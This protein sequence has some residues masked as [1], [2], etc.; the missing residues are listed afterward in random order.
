MY[1][2]G[3]VNTPDGVQICGVGEGQACLDA[4]VQTLVASQSLTRVEYNINGVLTIFM[5][6]ANGKVTD[7]AGNVICATGGQACL[8]SYV[9]SQVYSIAS[10]T[11]DGVVYEFHLYPDGSVESADGEVICTSGGETCLQAHIQSIVTSQTTIQAAETTSSATT[12]STVITY[13]IDGV[14]QRFT[15]HGDGSVVD[16]NGAVICAT[17]GQAC[18]EAWVQSQV[19]SYQIVTVDVYGEQLQ[20]YLYEDGSVEDVAS[21]EVVC[22]SGGTVCLQGYL[23]SLVSSVSR[24]V[25]DINGVEYLFYIDLGTGQVTDE[26]ENVI[27]ATGGEVCLQ[28]YVQSITYSVSTINGV[29]YRIYP[30]GRV[31]NTDGTEMICETGGID[32]LA[33]HLGITLALGQEMSDSASKYSTLGALTVA[34]LLGG[35]YLFQKRQAKQQE[36]VLENN[37]RQ[38]LL[39]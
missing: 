6:D 11:I 13:T 39:Q 35:V 37:I 15:I 25:F 8:T 14:D 29:A 17:G 30:D 34:V 23:D 4:H 36:L 2:D 32:C 21:G 24:V 3:R 10:Y 31:Y 38:S 18:L 33:A 12:S 19:A 20:F 16:A 22:A 26:F 7:E 9:E 1:Q 27:C 28:E 5:I